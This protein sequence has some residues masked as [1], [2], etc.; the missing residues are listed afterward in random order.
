MD[1]DAPELGIIKL[2][3]LLLNRYMTSFVESIE[4]TVKYCNNLCCAKK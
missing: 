3:P 2:A 1:V 4:L